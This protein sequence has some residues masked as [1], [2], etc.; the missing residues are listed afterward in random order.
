MRVLT[1]ILL[2]GNIEFIEGTGLELDVQG[3]AGEGDLG[4]EAHHGR[5]PNPK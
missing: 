2:L 5:T 4:K 1:A 3:N